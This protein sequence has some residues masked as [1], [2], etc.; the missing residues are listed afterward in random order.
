[1]QVAPPRR[2]RTFGLTALTLVNVFWGLSFIASKFALDAGMP[3]MTLAF[4]RYVI[5]VAV[6]VPLTLAR[7]K[8]LAIARADWPA[9]ALSALVGITVYYYFEYT[10]MVYTTAST[11]SLILA[12]VPVFSLLYEAVFRRKR[13]GGLHWACVLVSLAGVFFVIAFG[14]KGLEGTGSLKGNLLILGCCLSWV[15]YIQI[16]SGLRGKYASL[17]LTTWQSVFAAVTLLPFALMERAQWVP[18]PLAAWACVAALAL[19]CS[20]LCYFLYAEALS[21]VEPAT[22][23]LFIN[24]NPIAAVIGGMLLLGERLYP[25]QWVGGALILISLFISNRKS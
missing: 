23:A 18:V 19:I 7:D 25:L 3:P 16:N 4:A 5:T 17:R 11:A 2:S 20:G 24:I 13:A 10:G 8:T 22:A 6:M 21:A 12:S 1:M 14:G 9:A 15:A